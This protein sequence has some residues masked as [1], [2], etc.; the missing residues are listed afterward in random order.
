MARWGLKILGSGVQ[1]KAYNCSHTSL[2]LLLPARL[3]ALPLDLTVQ[4]ED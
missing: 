4:C 2:T 3:P 1:Q